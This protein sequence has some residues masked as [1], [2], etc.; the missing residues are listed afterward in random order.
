MYYNSLRPTLCLA[1]YA[2]VCIYVSLCLLL[3]VVPDD[4]CKEKFKKSEHVAFYRYFGRL[5]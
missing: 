4:E 2:D 3:S 1:V 5:I